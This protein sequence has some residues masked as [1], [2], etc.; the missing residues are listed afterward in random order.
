[1]KIVNSDANVNNNDNNNNSSN[2]ND[3]DAYNTLIT[4]LHTAVINLF[5]HQ[6]F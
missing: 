4:R 1:M 2:N 3:D 5:L 6:F